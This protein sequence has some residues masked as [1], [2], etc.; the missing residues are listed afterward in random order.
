MRPSLVSVVLVVFGGLAAAACFHKPRSPDATGDARPADGGIDAPLQPSKTTVRALTAGDHHACAISTARSVL[1]WGDNREGQLGSMEPSTGRPVA[2]AGTAGAVEIAAGRAHTC[3]LRDAPNRVICWGANA[4]NQ[5]GVPG[6]GVTGP[7]TVGLPAGFEPVHIFA[8]GDAT[9]ATDNSGTAQCWG[10]IDAPTSFTVVH[11]VS[12]GTGNPSVNWAGFALSSEQSCAL[13][14]DAGTGTRTPWCWGESGLGQAGIVRGGR[15]ALANANIVRANLT[16]L[17][18]ASGVTM[19]IDATGKVVAWGDIE[20]D[21]RST[22]SVPT[23]LGSGD[24]T[25]DVLAVGRNHACAIAGSVLDCWGRDDFGASGVFVP[26]SAE[27]AHQ[28]TSDGVALVAGG[29]GFTCYATGTTTGA[30]QAYCIGANQWGELGFGDV[31]SQHTPLKVDVDVSASSVLAAGWG[32]TCVTTQ[33]SGTGITCWGDDTSGQVSG[34]PGVVGAMPQALTIAGLTF[35]EIVAAGAQHTCALGSDGVLHCAGLAAAYAGFDNDGDVNRFAVA[36]NTTCVVPNGSNE[37]TRCAGDDMGV[38]SSADGSGAIGAPLLTIA[39]GTDHAAGFGPGSGA[40]QQGYEWG[41]NCGQALGNNP[42]QMIN[43]NPG[44]L[45]AAQ[46]TYG[47][48]G[49]I[50][51]L[52][53]SGLLTCWGAADHGVDGPGAAACTTAPG[54]KISV[55]GATFRTSTL[56]VVSGHHACALLTRAGGNLACWGDNSDGSF[57]LPGVAEAD[58]IEP[59]AGSGATLTFRIIAGGPHH[60]CGITAVAADGTPELYCWGLNRF[61]EV[62]NGKRAHTEPVP[63][64]FPD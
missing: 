27:A 18:V 35:A 63:V 60:T 52:G 28:V 33:G 19:G 59:T 30:Y 20:F 53:F 5:T 43:I 38:I 49:N 24:I 11:A 46:G 54:P 10:A 1:C 36:D 25:A 4:L 21:G 37:L 64:Q 29:L 23:L 44:T 13:L 58:L 61:G 34:M 14:L 22:S 39:I 47:T 32:H 48:P 12:P 9:C 3:I 6:D 51:L 41:A 50:C 7:V 31:T 15:I 62:G 26:T 56:P 17:R 2:V 45:V 55:A 16:S 8:G 40:Q 57:G 42:P